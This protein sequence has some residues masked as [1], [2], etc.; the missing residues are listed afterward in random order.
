MKLIKTASGKKK[1]KISKKEWTSIGKKAGWMKEST[2]FGFLPDLKAP[3]GYSP[4][5]RFE[6]SYNWAEGFD[7]HEAEQLG[8]IAFKNGKEATPALD[9][10]LMELLKDFQT[11]EGKPLLEAWLKG[12]NKANLSE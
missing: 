6:Q 12:W 1:L 3:E 4:L 11:G 10:R 8:K 7:L 9:S 5:S 2:A